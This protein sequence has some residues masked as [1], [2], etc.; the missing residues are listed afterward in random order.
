AIDYYTQAAV[1]YGSL[2]MPKKEG[3]SY[4][5]SARL[6]VESSPPDKERAYQDYGKA[7]TAFQALQRSLASGSKQSDQTQ[8]KRND[9]RKQILSLIGDIGDLYKDDPKP[10]AN[11][12]E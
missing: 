9:A 2:D 5:A 10:R 4:L 6:N 7:L 1:I 3:E 12:D 11:P 8:D